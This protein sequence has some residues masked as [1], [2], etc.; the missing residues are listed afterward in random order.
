MKD[1]QHHR[2]FLILSSTLTLTH[3]IFIEKRMIAAA[4][5]AFHYHGNLL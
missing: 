2:Y 1:L 4:V 3:D 5:F